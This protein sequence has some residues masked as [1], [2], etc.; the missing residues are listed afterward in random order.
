[1]NEETTTKDV[2]GAEDPHKVEW[3]KRKNAIIRR[4]MNKVEKINTDDNKETKK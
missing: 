1:M 4:V 2:C 3:T